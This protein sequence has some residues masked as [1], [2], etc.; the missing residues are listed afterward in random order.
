MSQSRTA[1]DD[2][3]PQLSRSFAQLSRMIRQGRSFSGHE[4]NCCYFNTLGSAAA[5]GRFADVS[6]A[7]GLDYP[8]DGRAAVRVDWDH[9][10][11]EELW[12]SNRNAPRVR[13]LRND[14]PSGNHFLALR[15]VGDGTTCNRDAIGAR[16]VVSG[17]W[18]VASGQK[19]EQRELISTLRAGEGFLS[20]SSKWLHFGLG[21]AMEDEKVVVHWPTGEDDQGRIEEF[22]GLAA[23]GMYVL[24]KGTGQAAPW[25]RP[26]DQTADLALS[27]S[28]IEVPALSS[29]ARI[30]LT[31]LIRVPTLSYD[32]FDGSRWTVRTG[33][34]KPRLV[35]LWASWC[36]PCL[37]EL[38]EFTK[39]ED[40][41]RSAGIEVLALSVDGLGDNRSDP[42]AAREMISNVKF[43]FIAG[44][45]TPR[46]LTT[47]QNVHDLLIPLDRPV[48]VPTSFLIDKLGRVVAIY[49][50]QASIDDVIAAV[51]HAQGT[52]DER[53]RRAS[54]LAGR[55]IRHEPR[56]DYAATVA[57]TTQFYYATVMLDT[58]RY[59]DAILNFQDVL[60]QQ[61]DSAK[62]LYNLG[63]ALE[64]IGET[65]LA[66]RHY[67][68]AVGHDPEMAVARKALGGLLLKRREFDAAIEQYR[69]AIR[70]RPDDLDAQTNLGAA[71][72]GKGLIDEAVTTFEQV[73]TADGDLAEARY[74]LGAILMAQDKLDEAAAQF[75]R[76]V[77]IDAKYP[78]AHFALG[79]L[80]ERNGD[81]AAAK[82]LYEQEVE[83][84]PKSVKAHS[85]L[86]LL[87]ER[88][89]RLAEAAAHFQRVL[90]MDPK[91][92]TARENLS[93]V[94][95]SLSDEN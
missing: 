63:V 57:R 85:R 55:T 54:P 51:N 66:V 50:G 33:D 20:Q 5:G 8:T 65:D 58:G 82:E 47:L 27:P 94:R 77:E 12:T 87:L 25:K 23:D 68:Q 59:E 28:E 69:E 32:D 15:L 72:A 48:P 90:Q 45:A 4:R 14:T 84:N 67:Q 92:Q 60:A 56:N 46:L 44:R 49:K 76:V 78:D 26:A 36:A 31:T 88:E 80:A 3:E 37:E 43:P 6:A 30:P 91:D 62:T 79:A 75:A 53:F 7:S 86:G 64:R 61:P 2:D 9:D 74:N 38:S 24:T 42:A 39:R 16:V 22:S 17:Q 35:N 1:E 71:L 19:G 13:L 18:S 95:A 89:G 11:D 83:A 70:L 21:E 81:R 29:T 41:L 52:R 40:E 73:I 10:G 93:R 34:G